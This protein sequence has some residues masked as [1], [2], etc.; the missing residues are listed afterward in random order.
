MK[1][2][3]PGS[4]KHGEKNQSLKEAIKA[5]ALSAAL[6]TGGDERAREMPQPVAP[7]E[8]TEKTP[9]KR[10][11]EKI[12]A[13]LDLNTKEDGLSSFARNRHEI[14]KNLTKLGNCTDPS[15]DDFDSV[16][17]CKEIT[18]GLRVNDS[19]FWHPILNPF[20]ALLYKELCDKKSAGGIQEHLE[21]LRKA[22]E[23]NVVKQNF[24]VLDPEKT[25]HD[26]C[27]PSLKIIAEHYKDALVVVY[28]YIISLKETDLPPHLKKMRERINQTY[29][30]KVAQKKVPVNISRETFLSNRF[31]SNMYWASWLAISANQTCKAT[32]EQIFAIIKSRAENMTP[33]KIGELR[34]EVLPVIR[35]IIDLLS[36][37]DSDEGKKAYEAL[38]NIAQ[39]MTALR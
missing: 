8:S 33:K 39:S 16:A 28:N 7:H 6:I 10:R 24:P 25:L 21:E 15:K 1:E 37:D 34:K 11:A 14:L 13:C 26:L 22:I 4:P 31:A 29:A 18:N 2:R 36:K 30:E 17:V 23:D 20:Y 3:V 38:K 12:V 27:K 9:E 35:E 19:K 32:D 5:F